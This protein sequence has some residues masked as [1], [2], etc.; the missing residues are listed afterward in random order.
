MI[1]FKLVLLNITIVLLLPILALQAVWVRKK[2]MRLAEPSGAREYRFDSDGVIEQKS[3]DKAHF[4][5]IGDSA[6]AGVGA[7]TQKQALSGYLS[8]KLTPLPFSGLS[9]HATTGFTSSDVASLLPSLQ[10][11]STCSALVSMGVNDVTRF[12]SLSRWKKNLCATSE[13]LT[14]QLNCKHII[15]T[16]L[17]PMHLFPVIPQPLRALLGYRAALLNQALQA[18]VSD[19]PNACMLTINLMDKASTMREMQQ[20]GL[21]AE[22]G[23]HPSSAGYA[24]WANQVVSVI[25]EYGQQ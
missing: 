9:L 12:A 15:Y 20:S 21:M 14:N 7:T 17:P 8:E 25:E 18:H 23:F 2:A 10:T 16:A 11:S 22:D 4:F 6:A 13:H 3:Q 1:Y 19:T 5:I 24:I